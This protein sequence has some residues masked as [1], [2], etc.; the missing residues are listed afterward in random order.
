MK[1]AR[2]KHVETAE[3]QRGRILVALERFFGASTAMASGLFQLLNGALAQNDFNSHLK[4]LANSGYLEIFRADQMP[5]YA[6]KRSDWLP[7]ETIMFVKLL[8]IG[9]Q[10]LAGKAPYDPTVQIPGQVDVSTTRTA[11]VERREVNEDWVRDRFERDMDAITTASREGD[12]L[13]NEVI[14]ALVIDGLVIDQRME[15]RKPGRQRRTE[16]AEQRG[17]ILLALETYHSY[18]SS[19]ALVNGIAARLEEKGLVIRGRSALDACLLDLS[20]RGYVEVLRAEEL[21]WYRGVPFLMALRPDELLLAKVLPK[22][23]ELLNGL[24]RD[25]EV[26]F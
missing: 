17:Y 16:P 11:A 12:A 13:A 6:V 10:L 8:P 9:F 7:P 22:G 4:G 19:M 5:G 24:T 18:G 2:A 25:P 23:L 14:R 1:S 15:P 3:E 21:P 20:E 26:K